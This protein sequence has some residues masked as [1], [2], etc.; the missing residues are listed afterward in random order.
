MR[1]TTN[2]TSTF[3][4]YCI[5]YCGFGF[6]G[7]ENDNE[8]KG[9]GNQ[10]DYGFRIYDPR[11]GK[12]FSVD[13]LT[14]KYPWYTPYQFAGNQ[15]IWAIDLDGLEEFVIT[16]YYNNDKYTGST[17]FRI[18]DET[19]R[20]KK[21][22]TLI[23]NMN[24]NQK[25]QMEKNRRLEDFSLLFIMDKNKNLIGLRGGK[26]L[27]ES[28]NKSESQMVET[29]SKRHNVIF[30]YRIEPKIINFVEPDNTIPVNSELVGKYKNTLSINPEYELSITGHASAEPDV[31][32]SH[33]IEISK[34][35]AI[36]VQNVMINGG[37]NPD[38]V[39]TNWEGSSQP[40][41]NTPNDSESNREINRRV[42]VKTTIPRN[43]SYD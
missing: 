16:R 33:N 24:D 31:S 35:R 13:P 7:K 25:P 2:I 22:G 40:I 21:T 29:I 8:V 19:K 11:I 42:E 10:Q 37:I 30:N 4:K 23:I 27:K 1:Q 32:E 14:K 26:I 20:F 17:V 28:P 36:N 18:D 9:V 43:N 38:R 41:K 15:P 6:N 39:N 12:F 3:S 34:R 5:G